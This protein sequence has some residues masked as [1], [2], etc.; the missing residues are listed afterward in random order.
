MAST[1]RFNVSDMIKPVLTKSIVWFDLNLVSF[2]GQ[3]GHMKSSG[4]VRDR[5]MLL[6]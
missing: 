2:L 4:N 5:C 6:L 1:T 3:G